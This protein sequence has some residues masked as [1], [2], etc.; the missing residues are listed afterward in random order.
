MIDQQLISKQVLD[1]K[2]GDIIK[3]HPQEFGYTAGTLRSKLRIEIAR[4]GFGRYFKVGDEGNLVVIRPRLA[5]V[6]QVGKPISEIISVPA[7]FGLRSSVEPL[8]YEP[9]YSPM[10]TSTASVASTI[11]K[12]TTSKA[13]FT[14]TNTNP[15]IL[16]SLCVLVAN[17][18]IETAEIIGS[19][20]SSEQPPIAGVEYFKTN[21]GTLII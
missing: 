8:S 1:L 11:N 16:H 21:N 19:D 20:L 7:E 2:V 3:L 13:F 6:D 18:I 5:P 15:E 10:P 4:L 12:Q 9:T 14:T 17:K